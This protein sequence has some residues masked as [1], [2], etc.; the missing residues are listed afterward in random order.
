MTG[1][2]PSDPPDPSLA[3]IESI[4][5]AIPEFEN[6]TISGLIFDSG[7]YSPYTRVTS[8]LLTYL[9]D[10][11]SVAKES[12]WAL[13]HILI[14]GQYT[15][16]LLSVS[17][18][19]SGLFGPDVSRSELRKLLAKVHQL[20]TYLLSTG[21]DSLHSQVVNACTTTR[22]TTSSDAL[23]SFVVDVVNH[24]RKEDSVR[25]ALVLRSVLKHLLASATKA[26]SDQWLSL[27]RRLEKTGASHRSYG[28]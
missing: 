7:G 21:D 19:P 27:A 9:G 12:M 20:S 24:A 10:N 15:N 18:T 23:I 16:D 26:D 2:L 22:E 4:I 11:R 17:E 28:M 6:P 3:L 8:A 1:S 13:R 25:D 14:L 5:P